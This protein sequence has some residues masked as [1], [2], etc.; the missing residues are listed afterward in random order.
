MG[1]KSSSIAM[2]GMVY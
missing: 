1:G 2:A